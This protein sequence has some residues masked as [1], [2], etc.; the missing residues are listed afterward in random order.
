MKGSSLLVTWQMAFGTVILKN[1]WKTVTWNETEPRLGKYCSK[2]NLSFSNFSFLW[3]VSSEPVTALLGWWS[4]EE[5]STTNWTWS[6]NMMIEWTL[7]TDELLVNFQP[8]NGTESNWKMLIQNGPEQQPLRKTWPK[9]GQH[10]NKS[11]ASVS[12]GVHFWKTF[13][14]VYEF[15]RSLL[16]SPL[17]SYCLQFRLFHKLL[18]NTHTQHSGFIPN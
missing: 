8:W 15:F 13:V 12:D 9:T 16:I 3:A 7:R 14:T 17:R 11:T 2:N 6:P 4:E 10:R 5:E 18:I 1:R